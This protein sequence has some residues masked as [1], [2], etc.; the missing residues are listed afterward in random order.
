MKTATSSDGKRLADPSSVRN[1]RSILIQGCSSSYTL[2]SLIGLACGG[3]IWRA[4][5]AQT[6]QPGNTTISPFNSIY[7]FGFSWT[8]TRG[9]YCNGPMWPEYLSTN[10]ALPYIQ[11][12]N[13]A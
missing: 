2:I 13:F 6:L 11:A 4:A 5:I 8:D 3:L 7:C 12:N 9:R 1:R 10:F